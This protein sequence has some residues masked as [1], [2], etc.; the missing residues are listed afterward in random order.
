MYSPDNQEII[1]EIVS[2]ACITAISLVFGRK[3]ASIDGPVL[4]IRSLLLVLYGLTWAFNLISCMLISTNN[5]N[6]ISCILGLF[7]CVFV[8]TLTKM[9]LYL[10]FI[11]KIYIISVPNAS[12]FK[13]PLYIFNLVLLTPYLGLMILMIVYRVALV[14]DEFPYHCTIGFQLPASISVLSYDI[15][16]NF[17]YLGIFIKF[18]L[19]P[20][21]AQQTTR[22]ASS[23]HVMAKRST[24]AVL[25]SLITVAANYILMV[26]MEGAERGLIALTMSTLDTTLVACAIHW[27]TTHPSELQC[28]EKALQRTNGDKPV[29]LEIK[30]HQEVVVLT[31]MASQA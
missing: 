15:L 11:E 13:S 16:M 27:V 17:L 12:R 24:I 31:E 6:Y 30:Q 25:I 20:N 10:Y 3:V 28:T 19:F 21:T 14:H 22:H 9:I 26:V 18:C 23:L 29:K 2:V 7:N 5:G 4:Y 8:Y 1:S